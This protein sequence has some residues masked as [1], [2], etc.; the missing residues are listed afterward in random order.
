MV[1]SDNSGLA[2]VVAGQTAIS[3]VE[4]SGSGLYYRGY[5]INEL[6]QYSNFEEVAYLLIYGELPAKSQLLEYQERLKKLRVLPDSLKSVLQ[7]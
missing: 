6:A 3:T 4:T 2:G 7:Q 5:S 1:P